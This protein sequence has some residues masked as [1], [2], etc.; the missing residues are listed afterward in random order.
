MLLVL[1]VVALV[2]FLS[3]YHLRLELRG[4]FDAIILIMSLVLF[5]LVFFDFRLLLIS[6]SKIIFGLLNSLAD[7]L[8][9]FL[10]P[11]RW[12]PSLLDHHSLIIS[13]LNRLLL[14]SNKPA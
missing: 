3:N 1:L 5:V 8:M 13:V 6:L 12:N 2:V 10:G 14:T 9:S 11:S 7:F 4:V